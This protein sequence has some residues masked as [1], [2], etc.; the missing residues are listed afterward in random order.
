MPCLSVFKNVL[1][2]NKL[3]T[4][5]KKRNLSDKKISEIVMELESTDFCPSLNKNDVN[6]SMESLHNQIMHCIDIV[7]PE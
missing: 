3:R 6:H 7:S 2:G 4:K 5:I 1:K